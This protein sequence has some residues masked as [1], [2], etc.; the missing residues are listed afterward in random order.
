MIMMMLGCLNGVSVS[1]IVL[2]ALSR[3]AFSIC[4]QDNFMATVGNENTAFGVIF[5][6]TAF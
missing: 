1:E 2:I 4:Y 5:I 3:C 6:C